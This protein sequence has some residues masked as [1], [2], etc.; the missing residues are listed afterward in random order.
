MMLY[1]E[2]D[3]YTAI[4]GCVVVFGRRVVK[5]R[6]G[7]SLRGVRRFRVHGLIPCHL[8]LDRK[9][10]LPT[11][12]WCLISRVYT[13]HITLSFR[14]TVKPI[15][16][17]VP[18]QVA[19]ES[20]PPGRSQTPP[21]YDSVLEEMND[22]QQSWSPPPITPDLGVRENCAPPGYVRRE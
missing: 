16:L 2:F 7:A 9:L 10:F 17:V 3:G 15:R 21:T 13:L 18:L 8:P 12:H 11:F 22:G 14:G 19:V 4:F 6:V 20:S 5:M 1:F